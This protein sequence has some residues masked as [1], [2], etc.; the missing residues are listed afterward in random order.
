MFDSLMRDARDALRSVRRSPGFSALV[1]LILAAG[2]GANVAMFSVTNA[3]LLKALPFP[4][5]DRLV[6]GRTTWNGRLGP[7]VAVPDFMD[8]RDRSNAF[9]S[10][11]TILGASFGFA[12]TGTQEP[13]WAE[14]T[15]VSVNLFR[16]LGVSPQ[17]GRDFTEDEGEPDA[18]LVAMISDGY[19]QRRFGGTGDVVGSILTIDGDP[20]TIVG[21]LP[22]GFHLLHDVDLWLPMRERGSRASH[23]WLLVG[24]LGRSV[25]IEEAQ[26][27][28]DVISAQLADAFP[29]TNENKALLLTDLRAAMGEQYRLG[30]MLL[31]GAIGLVLLIAC[32]NVASLLLARSSTRRVELS[33]RAALGA[34]RGRLARQLLAESLVLAICAALLGFVIALWLQNL[35]VALLPLD[36]LGIHTVGVSL[37]MLLFTL[38]LSIGTA[39]AFGGGP[40][41]IEF[42][43]QSGSAAAWRL[44]IVCR[45][46]LVAAEE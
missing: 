16:T 5:P 1:I 25:S 13:E 22:A 2:I 36:R 8:Y 21:V 37:P 14:G 26:S 23:S 30:L 40:G 4:D 32:A 20:F 43:N 18:P 9:E 12:I 15:L 44:P 27:R 6:M 45:R 28:V 42:P 29:E 39:L 3:A 11:G 34:S 41:A 46:Q 19:W 33:V 7:S 31:L 10:L 17:V 24:R 38:G 35:I